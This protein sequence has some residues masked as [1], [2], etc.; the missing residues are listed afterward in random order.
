MK[1]ILTLSIMLA[2]GSA[3]AS[4]RTSCKLPRDQ[5]SGS[6]LSQCDQ[7]PITLVF[8]QEFY[9]QNQGRDALALNRAVKTWNDWAKQKGKVAFVIAND[10]YG[11]EIPKVNGCSASEYN[12]WTGGAVGVWKIDGVGY[13]ANQ[14]PS[15]GLREDGSMGKILPG[16]SQTDWSLQ[17]G[18]IKEASVLLNF[19][20]F[21]APG[22]PRIDVE[23]MFLHE[24][25]HVLGLLHSCNGSTSESA[26]STTAPSCFASTTPQAYLDAVMFPFLE[27]N[28]TRRELGENDFNR[29][30]C[31]Y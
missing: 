11:M 21:N 22:K 5:G 1:L 30:N 2:A 9:R 26:D 7:L 31:L 18:R 25:G 6:L 4:D 10:G 23:S 3:Q 29:I 19:E 14:R 15:C 17:K 20:S 13:R 16:Q 8:D 24:L 28:Q 27:T 12:R